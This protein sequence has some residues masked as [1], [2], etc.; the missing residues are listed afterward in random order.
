MVV[1]GSWLLSI[2]FAFS[3]WLK[4]QH[5]QIDLVRTR[6][7]RLMT[8][9]DLVSQTEIKYE[10]EI[11]AWNEY[12][13]DRNSADAALLSRDMSRFHARHQETLAF[14]SGAMQMES[15]EGL[16]DAG[17]L[18]SL[19]S[20]HRQMT[21]AFNRQLTGA[22]ALRRDELPDLVEQRIEVQQFFVGLDAVLDHVSGYVDKEVYRL[23]ELT[24]KFNP[25]SDAHIF[26]FL[27]LQL[28]SLLSFFRLF[29]VARQ[30][31]KQ[32]ERT[33]TI[34]T[35]IADG[36]MVT[37]RQ[38]RIEY[39]N[40]T[41]EMLMGVTLESVRGTEFI[42]RFYRVND[43]RRLV[44]YDPVTDV[45]EGIESSS[46]DGGQTILRK[47]DD[48]DIPVSCASAP[49]LDAKGGM[50]GVVLTFQDISRRH[51]L[52]RQVNA[53][54]LRFQSIFEQTGMG[55]VFCD[56]GS[57]RIIE[58]NACFVQMVGAHSTDQ[59]YGKSLTGFYSD[60]ARPKAG[61]ATSGRQ[62]T[63]KQV[64][65]DDVALMTLQG[66]L[67]WFRQIV[68]RLEDPQLTMKEQRVFTFWDITERVDLQ[69]KLEQ[70]SICDELT[71]LG[72]RYFFKK[73][74]SDIIDKKSPDALEPLALFLIDI[75][76]FK[77]VN[78][79]KGHAV[80]DLLLKDLAMRL[81]RVV[82]TEDRVARLGGDEFVILVQHAD[83]WR[84]ER[85]IESCLQE[86]NRPMCL[87]E[88]MVKVTVSGGIS[89][90]PKHGKDHHTLLRRADLAMYAGKQAGKNRFVL[91]DP[92]IETRYNEEKSLINSIKIALEQNEFELYFQ[93]QVDLLRQSLGINRAEA[94]IRWNRPGQ[95]VVSPGEFIAA[96]ERGGLI[97]ELGAWVIRETCRCLQRWQQQGLGH[98]GLGFNVSPQQL[99]EGG[100]VYAE[101]AA[102][103]Q[104]YQVLPERLN[105]EIT[106]TALLNDTS[107]DTCRQIHELGIAV[108]LD[109]FGTG[110]SSLSLLQK[111][112]LSSLKIDQSFVKEMLDQGTNDKL[113][114]AMLGLALDLELSVV[115]EGVET[116]AQAERLT[117]LGCHFGQGYL[118]SKPVCEEDFLRLIKMTEAD[119]WVG[120]IEH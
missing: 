109:D 118:F 90:Y 31:G 71:G 53:G 9:K 75:D 117:E 20:E 73:F 28:I 72:N 56:P 113:V 98:I 99:L 52:M 3:W 46:Q 58:C 70:Q 17:V 89:L 63:V 11:Q 30:V 23:G 95:G 64:Q 40:P 47:M 32:D 93:A 27:I 49:V 80:G 114:R 1:V 79:S 43:E 103:M 26:S 18:K 107:L 6:V 22:M 60:V 38:A 36:V 62:E 33:F 100:R 42:S 115:A 25:W 112:P 4:Y 13:L 44:F 104:D 65:E 68:A 108:S 19:V 15:D 77:E 111:L 86:L 119:D 45:L 116:I 37:D 50:D 14:L 74:V 51:E 5:A 12:L 78:D 67:R 81:L 24:Q 97:V 48:R 96:A 94:L 101:I 7:L 34:F 76:N 54:R 41:A 29:W 106:E 83:R 61:T 82:G 84:I 69:K 21:S 10:R 39:M 57:L 35:S 92:K 120:S 66:N 2:A 88:E 91:F 59:L 55:V 105:M 16:A 8:V 85:V 87:D 102:A 110:Y